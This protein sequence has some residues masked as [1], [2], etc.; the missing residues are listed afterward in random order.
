MP[1]YCST[2]VKGKVNGGNM[3][4]IFVKRMPSWLHTIF[5]S[6][7]RR[8]LSECTHSLVETS[9]HLF[10]L[11]VLTIN[12]K[13]HD[14]VG[15]LTS[16]ISCPFSDPDPVV[17]RR[18]QGKPTIYH[19]DQNFETF[20][21]LKTDC[22]STMEMTMRSKTQLTDY[23]L[24][25]VLWMCVLMTCIRRSFTMPHFDGRDQINLPRYN[26]DTGKC[27]RNNSLTRIYF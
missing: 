20:E 13:T 12:M 23:H 6:L 17:S 15:W 27:R 1:H 9:V 11:S 14:A 16:F 24:F 19:F 3:T 21:W 22:H 7:W 18:K 4:R 8:R 5:T 2:K 26:V 10:Y 25:L